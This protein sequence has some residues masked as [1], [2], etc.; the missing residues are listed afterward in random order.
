MLV[1]AVEYVIPSGYYYLLAQI[2]ADLKIADLVGINF[3]RF[4]NS[5]FSGINFSNFASICC[6]YF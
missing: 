1:T 5:G 2:L 4:K 3:S 6:I